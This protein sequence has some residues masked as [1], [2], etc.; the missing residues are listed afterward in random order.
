L[1]AINDFLHLP[2]VDDV[3]WHLYHIVRLLFC[4]LG[5]AALLLSF[6]FKLCTGA[7]ITRFEDPKGRAIL[8]TGCDSGIGH[9]LALELVG[10]GWRV[11]AGCLTPE[12]MTALQTKAAGSTGTMVAVAMDVTKRVDIERVVKKIADECPKTLFAVVNNAGVDEG[13]L[14]DWTSE[15]TYRKL[16]DVNFF[17][18][19]AVCKACLPLLKES[20]GWIVNV[21]SIA[22]IFLGMPFMSAY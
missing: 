9:D 3:A 19:I 4:A 11:Y 14:V 2:I 18:M 8:I 16:M 22:G 6:L 15:E 7:F 12:G 17:A 13:G 20:K 1:N 5:A 10:K 21:T